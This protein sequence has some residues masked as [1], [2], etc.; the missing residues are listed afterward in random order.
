MYL[1]SPPDAGKSVTVTAV[2][3]CVGC[4]TWDL[5]FSPSAFS[6]LASQSVGRLSGVG[7]GP[8]FQ[9]FRGARE[10]GYEGWVDLLGMES[11]GLTSCL[12]VAEYVRDLLYGSQSRDLGPA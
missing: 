1:L 4:N 10:Q 12:A 7:A 6:K 2:D 3:R 5:D 11:S 9:D 8:G